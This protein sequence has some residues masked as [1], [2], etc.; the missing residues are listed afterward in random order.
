MKSNWDRSSWRKRARRQM[1]EYNNIEK[2]KIAE[3]RLN[4]FGYSTK[5][6]PEAMEWHFA[7][8]WGHLLNGYEKYNPQDDDIESL[9]DSI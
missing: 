7:G 6:L 5:I 3:K 2:L 4:D 8:S 9:I 1:P